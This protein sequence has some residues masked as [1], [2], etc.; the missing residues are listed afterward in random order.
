MKMSIWFYS[1][2]ALVVCTGCGKKNNEGVS[3]EERF[4]VRRVTIRDVM[5]QTGEVRPL[6]KVEL[7]SEASGRIQ[8]VYVKEGQRV[9][10]KDTILVID[11]QRLQ[12]QRDR[13]DLAVERTRIQAERAKR[14]YLQAESLATFGT[15]SA[16]ELQNRKNESDLAEISYKQQT[17]ELKDIVDQLQKTVITAPMTG[18][19]TGLTVEEGE[20]AVSA[21]SGFQAGTAIGTIADINKLE[22]VSQIGEV[23]YVNLRLGQQVVIRPEAVENV[24]THGT[25]TFIALSAKKAANQELGNFEVRASIDSIISGIAPGINVNVEYVLMEKK[26][27]VGVPNHF[28]ERRGDRSFVRMGGKDKEGKRKITSVPVELGKTDYKYFEI[29][30]GLKEGDVVFFKQESE[31]GANP[32]G[33]ARRN[34]GMGAP[35]GGGG[36]RPH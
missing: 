14:D 23:D 5:S 24:S 33:Q 4:K 12:Y 28:I 19:L 17:L 36:G 25:I 35:R 3:Y 16:N 11:P 15:I 20:I 18:V 6:V 31:D 13:M 21:T 32:P 27:V 9:M 26:D 34:A 2:L 7:K 8:K 10:R 29:V 30:S 22:V 1:A